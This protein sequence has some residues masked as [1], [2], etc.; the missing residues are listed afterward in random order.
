[1]VKLTSNSKVV[2]LSAFYINSKWVMKSKIY[3]GA[4]GSEFLDWKGFGPRN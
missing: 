4:A 1:M 2:T 3:P